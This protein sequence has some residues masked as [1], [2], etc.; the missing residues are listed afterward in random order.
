MKLVDLAAISRRHFF[1]FVDKCNKI[2]RSGH[3]LAF[4]RDLIA[5]HRETNNLAALIDDDDF[6]VKIYN[7][8]EEWDM[9]KRGAR[10]TSFAVLKESV[11]FWKNYLVELYDFKLYED[12]DDK[13]TED[14]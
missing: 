2:Y 4:Y 9:N 8:L 12:I 5:M 13:L 10:M 3:D 1:F 14:N 6:L 11:K 7:T